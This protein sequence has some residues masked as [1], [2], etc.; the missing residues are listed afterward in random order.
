M[1]TV[2]LETSVVSYL[3]QRPSSHIITA[4]HQ[5]ST[6]RWWESERK[7]Y[8]LVVSQYVVDE[9]SAG[10]PIYAAQRLEILE[11]VATLTVTPETIEI[12]DRILS[13]A[14][15]PASAKVDALH[16]ATVAH[17]RI[18]YLLT[19][20]CRHIANAKILPLIHRVLSDMGIPIPIIC[21]P[22]EMLGD[23]S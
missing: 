13:K 18:N 11:D 10:D 9:V 16:I 17:H 1:D 12:A 3:L 7:N 2:Y 23:E 8:D 19:W 21:T 20:N 5:L 15:L 14:I 22:E 6:Q 4:A